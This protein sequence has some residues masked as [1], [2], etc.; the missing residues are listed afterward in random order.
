[1]QTAVL[2]YK[3]Q[4]G[5]KVYLWLSAFIVIVAALVAGIDL[6]HNSSPSTSIIQPEVYDKPLVITKGGIYSGNWESLDSEVPAVEVRTSEPVIITNSNIRSAG[7][8][9]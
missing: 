2:Y 7:Y 6:Q 9:V 8:L 3:E 5:H 1:M 4:Q